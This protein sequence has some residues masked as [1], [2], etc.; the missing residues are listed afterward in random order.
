M[1]EVFAPTENVRA[2]IN[3]RD[4]WEQ[5]DASAE[6]WFNTVGGTA[7]DLLEPHER[8]IVGGPL[9]DF[10][11]LHAGVG[12]KHAV[13][14]RVDTNGIYQACKLIEKRRNAGMFRTRPGDSKLIRNGRHLF[15]IPVS[16]LT[17]LYLKTGINMITATPDQMKEIY[18]WSKNIRPSADPDEDLKRIMQTCTVNTW[19][20]F[21]V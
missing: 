5:S 10:W 17:Y 15:E 14:Y 16:L 20:N 3:W 19:T 6:E 11:K 9:Q 18:K 7:M 12:G 2:L 4:N 1:S 21:G 8:S 13:E